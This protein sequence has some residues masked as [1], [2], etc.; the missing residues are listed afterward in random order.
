MPQVEGIGVP[1][2]EAIQHFR[3]KVRLPT[4]SWTD[5]WQGQ[6]ARA[7][8]VAGGRRDDMLSDFQRAIQGALDDGTTLRTFRKDFDKIVEQYGWSHKGGRNWRSRV[9]FETNIR[10]SYAAGRWQQIERVAEKRPWLRYTAIEDAATRPEHLAWHGTI[11]RWDDPWW[12]THYTPN[13]W[14]CR[15]GVQQLS[16]DDLERFGFSPSGSAPPS[17]MVTRTVNTPDGPVDVLVPEGIDP[18]WAYNV[19]KADPGL[20]ADLLAQERHGPWQPLTAPGGSRP[21][22]PGR[23]VPA[24]PAA[25]PGPRVEGEAALRK[26]LR[27]AIGGDKAV[28]ADPLGD[29]VA[30]NQSLV[31][32]MIGD[33]TRRDGREVYWPFIPELI[34]EPAEIW[35]GF[36]TNPAGAVRLR[37]RY[38]KLFSSPVDGS[39]GLIAD[40]DDGRWSGLTFVRGRQADRMAGLR[41]GL[42]IYQ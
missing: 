3:Q 33:R 37:R 19:G 30:V 10:T 2:D 35:A 34:G 11:L 5:L 41:Q 38:V 9:I 29:R 36:E 13:G 17:P 1:F 40:V 39:V 21:R 32:H 8:V 25:S 28:Y 22:D 4:D 18:G 23:L 16:D 6:H 27:D 26:A 14:G 7:F 24:R 15:C 20:G 31:G 42:R 12:D